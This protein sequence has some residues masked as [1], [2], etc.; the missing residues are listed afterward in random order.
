MNTKTDFQIFEI[1]NQYKTPIVLLLSACGIIINDFLFALILPFWLV[2]LTL[3]IITGVIHRSYV[4]GLIG[5]LGVG[6][7][8][9]ISITIM[10][11]LNNGLLETMNLFMGAIADV[12]SIPLPPGIFII[13]LLS[14]IFV[15]IFALLGELIG[16]SITKIYLEISQPS[17]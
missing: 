1:I 12:L 4:G 14:L 15:S 16:T 9:F 3:G 6:L 2:P 5:V 8:R 11:V 10:I 17:S 13:V 7:G